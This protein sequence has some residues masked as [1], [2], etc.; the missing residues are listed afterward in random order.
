MLRNLY[1]KNFILIDELSIDFQEGFNVLTGETG[2]GK[3]IIID[4]ISLLSRK[5]ANS[6]LIKKGQDK[7]IIQGVFDINYNM[8]KI[9]EEAGLDYDETIVISRE[10]KADGKSVYRLNNRVVNG[11]LINECLQDIIDIHSQHDTQYL[12]NK[13]KHIELLDQYIDDK[14]IQEVKKQYQTYHQLAKELQDELDKN[15]NEQDADYYQFV[16]DEI[17]Q[18]KLDPQEE[19]ELK[20]K[21]EAYKS[22]KNNLSK[23]EAIKHIYDD[24]AYG[25]LYEMLKLF[26]SFQLEEA[27][28]DFNSA[29]ITIEDV[30]ERLD[31]YINAFNI[32]EDSI[33]QV[34]ERLFTINK[35]KHKYNR[36]VE[37]ILTYRQQL[38]EKLEMINHRQEYLA[39]KQKGLDDAYAAFLQEAKK[40]RQLRMAKAKELEA[41]IISNLQDLMLVNARFHI[42]ISEASASSKGIDNVEFYIAMNAGEDLK[43]LQKTASGGELSRLMLGLKV[44]FAKLTNV[45]TIIFD[46]IDTGVSGQVAAAIAQ[47]MKILSKTIQVFAITHLAIVASYAN[48][49]YKVIKQT[50]DGQTLTNIIMLDHQQRLAELALMANGKIDD[51]TLSAA[52][53]LLESNQQWD[54]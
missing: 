13:N 34:E 25:D 37:E 27:Y 51:T 16:I 11:L 39:I 15:Y 8:G 31:C 49:Q 33:N 6:D 50:Q 21:E 30:M 26:R 4:A 44:I 17:D 3:S 19:Y 35:L 38:M 18:A 41:L 43:P 52:K 36:S 47:K 20:Q 5:K 14:L 40:L 23:Y 29:I 48:E 54:A 45:E 12:L 28:N 9:L 46:E 24:R 10:I 32:D 53:G 2:A 7:A 22:I 1:I 42:E